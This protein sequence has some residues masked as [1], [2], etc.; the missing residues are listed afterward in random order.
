MGISVGE[1][2]QKD[3]FKNFEVIAGKQGLHKH[4]QGV[5]VLDAPD[6]FNWT[7]GREFIISSGYIFKMNPNLIQ[8]HVESGTFGKISCIGIKIGRFLDEMPQDLIRA[9]DD[10]KIPLL[11][12]PSNISWM[13]IMNTLNII[14]MNRNIE[15]FNIGKVHLNSLSDL[16]YHVR[17]IRKILTAVEF[18]MNFPAMLYDLSSDK[19][20]YSSDRF[21]S[22]SQNMQSENF[23]NPPFNFSKDILCDNLQMARY[24]IF[25][26][27]YDTPYS[28]I[29]VPI[30]VDSKARA[31]FVV[32]EAT[33]L[34]DY[35]DQ[36]ALRTGYVLL[37]ELHEQILVAQNI[38]DIGFESFVYNLATGKLANSHEIR[39]HAEELNLGIEEVYYVV[40][41]QQT[42]S[43]VSLTKGRDLLRGSIRGI[44]DTAECRSAILDDQTCLLLCRN[45]AN[46]EEK[47][48]FRE[49][50]AKLK[51]LEKRLEAD[52]E[53][54]DIV[55]GLSD[56]P[57]SIFEL[58]RNYKRC[59]QALE[60][61]RHLY[62]ENHFRRYSELGALA[63]LNIQADEL[64]LMRRDLESL[65]QYDD[66]GVLK[67]TLKT[68]LECKMN[69][70]LTAKTMFLHINTVRKR[71]E[72]V[73][74][75]LQ[76]DLEDSVTRLKLELLLRLT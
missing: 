35:F 60:I 23:W 10:F 54:T 63:W 7:S 53:D 69:F 47:H 55:F 16:S 8:V 3:F 19:A 2:L 71:I 41:M 31:Y 4:I 65:N 36:F 64:S 38:G 49:L 70:S 30:M 11:K 58:E 32:L 74:E 28:W 6:G 57:G 13:D 48:Y 24:R 33:G 52:I 20:Y 14:V 51:K 34:I 50:K 76:L 29:T 12:I 73:N 67:E 1:M 9:C 5:A 75:R 42:N 27:Q 68:Y 62:P 26:E 44:F 61:G 66:H 72:E 18:E 46:L 45:T 43:S 59:L 21:R 22:V 17:K 39:S 56:L 40:T 37:Q 25:D 15:H